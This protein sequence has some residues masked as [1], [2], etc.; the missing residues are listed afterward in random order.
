MDPS[1][2]WAAALITV[3][4]GALSGGLTNAIAVWM[5]FHPYDERGKGPFRIQG[6]IPKNKP[7]LAKAIGKVVGEKLL[8]SS[9]LV[10]RLRAPEVRTA[11]QEALDRLLDDLLEEEHGPLGERLDTDVR[12]AVDRAM[13]DLGTK[14]ASSLADYVGSEDF[15]RVTDSWAVK[16]DGEEGES[17]DRWL[18]GVASSP[19]VSDGIHRIVHNQLERMAEDETPLG[20]RIPAGL[21]PVVEQ[22]ITDAIP[23]AVEQLGKLLADGT[24]RD[25]IAGV[26]RDTFD[27]SMRQM[28]IHERLLAKIVVNEGTMDRLLTGL[29][30]T[31]VDRL[32]EAV[33]APAVKERVQAAINRGIH[34]ILE[35]PLADRIKSL[36]ED[37]T[38]QLED[39]VSGWLLGALQSDT[40][41]GS[42]LSGTK[43]ALRERAPALLHKA[44][45]SDTG[46]AAVVAAVSSSGAALLDKP[47]GRPA[48]WLGDDATAG[49]RRSAHERA[50]TWVEDQVPKVVAR[51]SIQEM[52][53]EK[54]QG[55]S[56]QRMEEIVRKVTQKELDLIVKLGY[57]LGAIVG[58]VAF[59]LNQ[60]LT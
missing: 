41:R 6:A 49:L 22:G 8:T 48:S 21:V 31:G 33:K 59:S 14:L 17:V 32:A 15:Q 47:I 56:T 20:E 58:A 5:L 39:T 10:E 37:R 50:W 46:K 60:V 3:A 19:E 12:R 25:S 11:F 30:K 23:G 43:G 40:V 53:E 1:F 42:L 38:Q 35:Q 2:P 29:E 51:L 13:G 54:V 57:L 28:M 7:R 26:L 16:L 4:V 36:S 44:L 45:E 24:L 52:V 9:D 27:R 55:F 18:T 34:S